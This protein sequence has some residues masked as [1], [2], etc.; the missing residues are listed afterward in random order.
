MN[1]GLWALSAAILLSN[2]ALA[3]EG[4]V[5]V[6]T[7]FSK[8]VTDP[9]KAAFEAAH[10]GTTL[11][12]QNKST[13]SGVVYLEETRGNNQTDLFWASAPDA[14]VTLKDQGLLSTFKPTVEGI[15]ETVGS[16]QVND[17][18]GYFF[19]FAASGYGMMWNER[20][21]EANGIEAPAE[22]NDLAEAQYHDHVVIAA[23]SRSGTTHLTVETIL[24]GE[25]WEEGW[26][27]LKLIG[28][29]F[30][31]VTDRSFGVPEAVNSGQAG[32]GIVIDFFGFAAR[33]SGFPVDFAYPSVTTVVPANIGIVANA[34]NQA[35]AEAFVNFLLSEDGQ[36]VLFDPAI[37]RLPINPAVY[38]RAPDGLPNPFKD[39][40]FASMITFDGN[41]SSQRSAVVDSLFDQT[42]TFQLDNLS[43]AVAAIQAAQA[44]AEGKDMPEAKAM[45][46]EA[47]GL[48]AG[49]PIT[50]KDAVSAEILGAFE[51]GDTATARQS[52]LEQEW[53][54]FAQKNYAEAK[55]KAEAAL[56]LLG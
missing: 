53:A 16:Y 27:L 42:V 28:G 36:L 41:V 12:V 17:R 33:A 14:F 49:V 15:P 10:P 11:E 51:G 30:Q 32:V 13:S 40:Q 6:V 38:D 47:I 19:G 21:L 5:T 50:E 2:V 43:A 35:G 23:P 52:Q 25:G 37:Q 26:K 56:A 39:P 18:D 31:Q 48:V 34:P 20:Y 8:D 44:A 22:W 46:E 29:N 24:Q 55:Q 54:A 9:I 1:K 45:I 4:T 3:Q 7:S